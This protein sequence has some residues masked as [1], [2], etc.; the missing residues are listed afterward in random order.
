MLVAVENRLYYLAAA[1]AENIGGHR[2]ELD[3]GILQHFVNTGMNPVVLFHQLHAV[4]R[5][6]P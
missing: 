5:Q 2:I 1:H 3:T 6:I 4:T